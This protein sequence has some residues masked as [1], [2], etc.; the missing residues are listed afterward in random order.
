MLIIGFW[1]ALVLWI[2]AIVLAARE[3]AVPDDGSAQS[4]G[5]GPVAAE[6]RQGGGR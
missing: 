2:A 5:F 6:T 1:I 4:V 3:L